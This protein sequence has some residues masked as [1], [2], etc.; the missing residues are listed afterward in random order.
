VGSI[1]RDLDNLERAITKA[2]GK[3]DT[4]ALLDDT[5]SLPADLR[6]LLSAA[7][8]ARTTADSA[9][10]AARSEGASARMVPVEKAVKTC[11]TTATVFGRAA[12]E[13]EKRRAY[14]AG[15]INDESNRLD[16]LAARMETLARKRS[17]PDFLP[18]MLLS[19]QDVLTDAKK[20][21]DAQDLQVLL[22]SV[23]AV[24]LAVA[25]AEKAAKSS[26]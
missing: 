9:L 24:Y 23:G 10:R 12:T 18:G 4:Y 11:V 7:E 14:I 21:C 1:F 13:Y 19:A 17:L 22:R 6:R 25:K 8:T 15:Q 2:S 5:M 26:K 3:Y 20:S 16:K